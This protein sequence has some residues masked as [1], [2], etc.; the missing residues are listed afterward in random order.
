MKIHESVVIVLVLMLCVDTH[1]QL[2]RGYGLEIGT[3]AANQTWTYSSGGPPSFLTNDRWGLT[4]VGFV[5]ILNCPNLS[6]ILEAQYRQKGMSKTLSQTPEWNPDWNGQSKTYYPRVDYLSIPLLVKARFEFEK[7]GLYFLAGP[8]FDFLIGEYAGSF[9]IVMD[10]F[11]A[12]DFGATIGAGAEYALVP[13]LPLL[14][15]IRYN[16]SF[17]NEFDNGSLKIRNHS[18]DFL[19]GVRL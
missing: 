9:D 17:Q 11:R 19:L 2:I 6:G 12:R 1:A 5:E 10:K 18:V 7:A 8:R 16:P 13:A 4:V 14:V 3:V 15:E